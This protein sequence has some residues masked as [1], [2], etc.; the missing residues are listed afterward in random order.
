M[1]LNHNKTNQED[2][3]ELDKFRFNSS[4]SDELY[5]ALGIISTLLEQ[6]KDIIVEENKNTKRFIA[7]I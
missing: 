1:I 7:D 2:V 6:S 4:I 5:F 3:D